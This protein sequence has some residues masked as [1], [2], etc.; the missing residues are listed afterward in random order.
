MM[1]MQ[2]G[3]IDTILHDSLI[4][5]SNQ[6]RTKVK[7]LNTQDVNRYGIYYLIFGVIGFILIFTGCKSTMEE[8]H[9]SDYIDLKNEKFADVNGFSSSPIVQNEKFIFYETNDMKIM[10]I[11]K[12]NHKKTMIAQ[13]NKTEAIEG[14][15][16]LSNNDIYYVHDDCLYKSSF[17]GKNVKQIISMEE[18]KMEAINGVQLYKGNI[19]LEADNKNF[20]T[21][22]IKLHPKTNKF[23]KVAE[24]VG[25]ECFYK[26]SLYYTCDGDTGI[27]KVDLDTLEDK[28]V[29]GKSW[30]EELSHNYDGPCYRGIMKNQGKLYYIK[31]SSL[32]LYKESKRDKKEYV[33]SS[34]PVNIIFY[35]SVAVGTVGEWDNEKGSYMQI[36]DIALKKEK[37]VRL[38]EGV[39]YDKFASSSCVIDDIVLCPSLKEGDDYVKG[40]KI[41]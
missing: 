5:K 19:Y 16:F 2:D 34:H 6:W 3:I 33:F 36:Y 10:R 12:R 11:D 41:P 32:Y 1:L 7:V 14:G 9:L 23:E 18:L 17:D 40:F 25:N 22:V 20:S 21:V 15:F 38:P 26:N 4:M 37:K 31:D 28:L 35:S 29:R 30:T 39:P 13:L 24:N 27:H 8:K